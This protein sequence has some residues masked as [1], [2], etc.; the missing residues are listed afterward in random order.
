M[1]PMYTVEVKERALR[2]V[3][4]GEIDHHNAKGLR[5][6]VDREIYFYRPRAVEISLSGVT[7]MDSA[8]LGFFMGRYN[9]CRGIG[10]A[11]A[12]VDVTAEVQKILVLS[13]FDKLL[14]GENTHT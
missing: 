2:I 3:L 10:A 8:G 13:G 1:E 12:L 14:C 11:F 9:L 4:H 7:F 5:E 6:G